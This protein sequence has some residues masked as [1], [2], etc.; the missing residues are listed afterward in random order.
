MNGALCVCCEKE[1]HGTYNVT[2]R[3]RI[4]VCYDCYE[5]GA[6]K[7]WL[8]HD[9]NT[10]FESKTWVT[11]DYGEDIVCRVF[12]DQVRDDTPEELQYRAW[13]VLWEKLLHYGGMNESNS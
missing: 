7:H 4:P 12:V 11:L 1:T 3:T 13:Q 8:D 5:S 9:P 2:K 10:P 6:L